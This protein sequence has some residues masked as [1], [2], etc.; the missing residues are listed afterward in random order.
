ME[1]LFKNFD[2][3]EV[4]SLKEIVIG[5]HGLGGGGNH[6]F[7]ACLSPLLKEQNIGLSW[8]HL[9]GHYSRESEELTI[10]GCFK[11]IREVE[12][13]IR[14]DLLKNHPNIKVSLFGASFGAHLAIRYLEKHGNNFYKVFLVVPALNQQVKWKKDSP[15]LTKPL[16]SGKTIPFGTFGTKVTP[17]FYKEFAFYDGLGVKFNRKD[18]I[19]IVCATGDTVVD[20]NQTERFAKKHGFEIIWVEGAEHGVR[21]EQDLEL[22]TKLIVGE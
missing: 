9:P 20:N 7:L 10:D 14:N 18:N 12:S 19:T 5:L 4:E 11:L 1:G 2:D 13:Y 6:S 22:F 15:E 17:K 16:E 3:K 21:R 8:F